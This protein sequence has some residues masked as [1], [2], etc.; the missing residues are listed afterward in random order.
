MC[1][2][3]R[4]SRS[5]CE[6]KGNVHR[7]GNFGIIITTNY[8]L[9]QMLST[10]TS[11]LLVLAVLAVCM[12]PHQCQSEG[13]REGRGPIECGLDHIAVIRL[14]P[15]CVVCHSHC[16]AHAYCLT[17]VSKDVVADGKSTTVDLEIFVL[18]KFRKLNFRQFDFRICNGSSMLCVM[19]TNIS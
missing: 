17:G 10:A 9:V 1:V 19:R 11:S 12:A 15:P 16:S 2:Y 3:L 4:C 7:A 5:L 18:Y 8:P 13:G 14:G 6:R